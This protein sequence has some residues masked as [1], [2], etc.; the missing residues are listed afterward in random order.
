MLDSKFA[1][2]GWGCKGDKDPKL[3]VEYAADADILNIV[4]TA[5]AK[6]MTGTTIAYGRKKAVE[7]LNT[8]N[9]GSKCSGGEGSFTQFVK[10][11]EAVVV[12][13]IPV[14]KNEVRVTMK[15]VQDVDLQLWDLDASP[16]VPIIGYEDLVTIKTGQ[17]IMS[18]SFAQAQTYKGVEYKW[19]GFD[20]VNGEKGNEYINIM[21]ATNQRLEMRAYG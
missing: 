19:S 12:G 16:A 21:G 11:D 3:I 1:T 7:I 10:M 20:G 15:S 14:E 8:F 13:Q 4:I 6:D 9:F 17:S 18:E 5:D 2:T